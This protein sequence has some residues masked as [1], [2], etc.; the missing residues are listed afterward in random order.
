[1]LPNT[2]GGYNKQIYQACKN[3]SEIIAC[4]TNFPKWKNKLKFSYFKFLDFR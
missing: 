2:Q 4:Y 3:V 1:M